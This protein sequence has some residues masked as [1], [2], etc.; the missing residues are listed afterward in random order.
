MCPEIGHI[1]KYKAS[2]CA[3]AQMNKK[4][5][6][7]FNMVAAVFLNFTLYGII[8]GLHCIKFRNYM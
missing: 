3:S 1:P 4:V 5:K 8:N 6:T 7:Q 2:Y